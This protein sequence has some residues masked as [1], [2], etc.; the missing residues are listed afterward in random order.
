M[1][2]SSIDRR[3]SQVHW[4]AN[5]KNSL[6][7]V[8]RDYDCI[9][10]WKGLFKVKQSFPVGSTTFQWQLYSGYIQATHPELNDL[11]QQCRV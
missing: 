8:L 10:A 2:F 5:I 4:L 11:G 1:I 9:A 3:V 6:L 7:P